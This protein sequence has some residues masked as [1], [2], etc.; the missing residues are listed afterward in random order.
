MENSEYVSASEI[1]DFVYCKKGWWMKRQGL[2]SVTSEMQMGT[3]KHNSLLYS[4]TRIKLLQNLLIWSGIILLLI[5]I[6][7]LTF[8]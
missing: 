6:L 7:L 2:L 1:G 4:L 3:E 8:L 5:L